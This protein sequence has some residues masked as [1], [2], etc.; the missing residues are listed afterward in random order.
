MQTT[1]PKTNKAMLR[2]S[3]GAASPA[4]R[5]GGTMAAT[6]ASYRETVRWRQAR[7]LAYFTKFARQRAASFR[8][9]Q[10][11]LAWR[12]RAAPLQSLH[13]ARFLHTRDRLRS[14]IREVLFLGAHGMRPLK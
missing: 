6:W 4:W 5:D 9:S 11:L 13:V 12:G 3:V 10:A 14:S 7:N 1:S 8:I 2:A